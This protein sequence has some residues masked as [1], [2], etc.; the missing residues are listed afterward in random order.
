MNSPY[1]KIFFE[2]RQTWAQDKRTTLRLSLQQILHEIDI[3]LGFVR[4]TL[5]EYKQENNTPALEYCFLVLSSLT[6]LS[7]RSQEVKTSICCKMCCELNASVILLSCAHPFQRLTNCP[8][9]LLKEKHNFKETITNQSCWL[10]NTCPV[11]AAWVRHRVKHRRR[12]RG[13]YWK[14]TKLKNL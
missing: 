5:K 10:G 14:H 6:V 3:L 9:K 12:W 8:S 2:S 4:I 11:P 13:R 1:L 7:W